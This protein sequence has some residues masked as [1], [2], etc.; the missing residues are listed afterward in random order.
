MAANPSAWAQ[1]GRIVL[2]QSTVLTGPLAPLGIQYAEGARL[3]FDQVNAQGGIGRR[4]IELKTLDDAYDPGRCA[5]N[6]RKLLAEDV[7]ALFGYVGTPTSQAALAVATQAHVPFIAPLTGAPALREPFNRNVFFLRASYDEEAEVIVKQQTSMNLSRIGVVYQTDAFGK[8]GLDGVVKALSARKLQPSALVA[9]DREAVD[10]SEPVKKFSKNW[11]E[12]IVMVGTLSPCAAF[13]RAARKAGFG[14]M[15]FCMSVVDT[16][17]LGQ[18]L[19]AVGA[20]VVVAQVLPSPFKSSHAASREFVDAVKK[21]GGKVTPGY[22]AFE[23][24]LAARVLVEGMRRA[25]GSVDRESLV[26]GLESIGNATIA[27]LP[28]SLSASSHVASKF[29]ELSMLTGDGRVKA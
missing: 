27:G 16:Q 29:V 15:C 13:I 11:P 28:V 20:G 2:G 25:R 6:T 19:G 10:M 22:T 24:Y 4:P 1:E 12:A 3:C 8:V 7:T 26:G 23:G 18:T 9:V 21:G 14:G 17:T 5:D